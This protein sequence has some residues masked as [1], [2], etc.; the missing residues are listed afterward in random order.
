[1]KLIALTQRELQ[2]CFYS[3]MAWLV[4]AAYLFCCGWGAAQYIDMCN[5]S[6]MDASMR[7]MLSWMEFLALF[8]VPLISMRLVAEEKK[9]GT[10]EMLVTAP[11]SDTSVVLSKFTGAL[12]FWIVLQVPTY[13]YVLILE[14]Y[15]NPEYGSILTGYLGLTLLGALFLSIGLFVSTVSRDQ[16]VAALV[17]FVLLIAFYTMSNFAIS[18]HSKW[19]GIDWRAVVSYMGFMAHYESF[20]K[21]V[22]DSR[23][24]TYYLSV[25]VVFLFLSVRALESRRWR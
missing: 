8:I 19:L 1:M 21:G 6:R 22:L 23:D 9:T 3:P 10:L 16:V 24:L 17:S 11:V 20:G 25:T 4:M 18:I 5:T 13:V 12:A 15:A 7:D 14:K 2:A